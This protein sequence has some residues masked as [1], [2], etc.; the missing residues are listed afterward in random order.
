[1]NIPV[2]IKE[3]D[4]SMSMPAM[5]TFAHVIREFAGRDPYGT[6]AGLVEDEACSC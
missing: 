5:W 6:L 4:A 2:E 1:L 3:E